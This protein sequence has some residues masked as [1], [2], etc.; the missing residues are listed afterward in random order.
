MNVRKNNENDNDSRRPSKS[1]WRFTA[2]EIEAIEEIIDRRVPESKDIR[3]AFATW[4]DDEI[5]R[6]I[7]KRVITAAGWAIGAIV[8]A[9]AT[10]LVAW[11]ISSIGKGAPHG[12]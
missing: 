6:T 12:N 7:G 8:T 11:L 3:E 1:A 10:A 5:D 9:S 2:D 4:L